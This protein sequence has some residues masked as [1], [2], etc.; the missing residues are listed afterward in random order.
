[1]TCLV[2]LPGK[3][4]IEFVRGE[5]FFRRKFEKRIRGNF[6]QGNLSR[7]NLPWGSSSDIFFIINEFQ[8]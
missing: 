7:G 4:K 3:R 1:M 6:P 5:T 8:R 2:N